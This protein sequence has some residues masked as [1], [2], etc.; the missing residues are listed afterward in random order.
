MG[1]G[2]LFAGH[3]GVGWTYCLVQVLLVTPGQAVDCTA[4]ATCNANRICTFGSLETYNY[5]MRH[6]YTIS[7]YP[8]SCM[9][10]CTC[11]QNPTNEVQLML[12][13]AAS[14]NALYSNNSL[15]N[16][17]IVYSAMVFYTEGFACETLV[18]QMQIPLYQLCGTQNGIPCMGRCNT[19]LQIDK[20]RRPCD[21]RISV[22]SAERS[23]SI[24]IIIISA[25]L[26]TWAPDTLD[27]IA[28]PPYT[29]ESAEAKSGA[30]IYKIV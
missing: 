29:R 7:G 16:N 23:I 1:T 28:P 11:T 20:P 27:D 8:V 24:G 26:F 17:P 9:N 30:D 2:G 3:S 15:C 6:L 18:R 21:A 10:Q 4:T 13:A 25:V 22:T 5:V 12:D 14:N 19:Y